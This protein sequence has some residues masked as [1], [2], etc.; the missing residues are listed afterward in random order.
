MKNTFIIKRYYLLLI[1]I[2]FM[3]TQSCID[4]IV[5]KTDPEEIEETGDPTDVGM[6]AGDAEL[7][8]MGT[9]GGSY[10]TK[11]GKLKIEIPQGA[12]EAGKDITSNQ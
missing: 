1:P 3:L 7:T 12:L 6:P 5:K 11:D 9:T 10:T 4:E 2:V 8:T